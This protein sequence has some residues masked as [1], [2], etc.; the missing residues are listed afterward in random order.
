VVQKTFM[1]VK[2]SI[3]VFS[4]V[5]CKRT[6]SRGER[7]FSL[8]EL[9]KLIG[10]YKVKYRNENRTFAGYINENLSYKDNFPN[11]IFQDASYVL[12]KEVTS[13]E[14][15]KWIEEKIRNHFRGI[16]VNVCK[17]TVTAI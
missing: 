2:I 16:Y 14:E 3:L 12:E 6:N 13:E 4:P 9:E 17:E 15:V 10:K 1:K 5:N 7:E 8:D 11:F